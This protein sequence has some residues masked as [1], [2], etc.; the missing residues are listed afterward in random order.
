[1]TC[2]APAELRVARPGIDTYIWR[3]SGTQILI[4]V[5]REG[6]IRVHE[7]PTEPC[8]DIAK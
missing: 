4:E 3:I 7:Q 6:R 1:M 5:E 8:R 2:F